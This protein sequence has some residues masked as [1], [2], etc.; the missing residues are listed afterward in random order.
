MRSDG[1]RPPGRRN[2]G[3]TLIYVGL[4]LILVFGLGWA[5]LYRNQPSSKNTPLS[6]A[7]MLT[8]VV[9]LIAVPAYFGEKNSYGCVVAML[10]SFAVWAVGGSLLA[11]VD[12]RAYE[13]PVVVSFLVE[14]GVLLVH[15]VDIAAVLAWT[16]GSFVAVAVLGLV[17]RAMK[18][19]QAADRR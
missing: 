7:M 12:R 15:V 16:V 2:G 5:Y 14:F 10:V 6:T 19:T 11:L 18:G 3:F 1:D 17:W 9:G 4:A 8:C 13:G